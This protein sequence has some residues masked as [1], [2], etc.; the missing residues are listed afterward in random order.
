[1]RSFL[2]SRGG[3]GNRRSNLLLVRAAKA[4]YYD[5]QNGQKEYT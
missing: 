1:M 2:C 5:V 4:L 3:A